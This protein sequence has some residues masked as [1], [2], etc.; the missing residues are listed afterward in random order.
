M[1]YVVEVNNL[2]R[3]FKEKVALDEVTIQLIPGKV[4][5]LLGENGA[6]KSTLIKHIIGALQPQ[7]GSVEVFGMT[8][9][10]NPVEVL[11]QIG[12]LSEDRDLPMWM[13]ANEL[14]NYT[15]SFFDGWDR[16]YA[17]ELLEKFHLDPHI[18]VK[19]MSRGEKARIGLITALAHR[20]KL[21]VL[22]EPSSGLDVSVRYDILSEV[23]RSV[24]DSGRTILFSSHL[25]DEVE[26]VT[27]NIIMINKGKKI[28]D[29]H[30]DTIK[31]QHYRYIVKFA[32]ETEEVKS[33]LKSD[34]Q[35]IRSLQQDTEWLV[36]AHEPI[37]DRIK[38]LGGEIVETQAASLENVFMD[39]CSLENHHG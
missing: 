15:A 6:G 17:Q 10:S 16:E 37:A 31:D 25:L 24:A 4:Y 8:P 14:L 32:D 36:V 13:R 19:N 1:K 11:S 27:D 5:G 12:Y 34:P 26:R 35:L 29:G 3:R 28:I 9:A 22:D 33:F 2:T 7:S 20:P 18:K 38:E 21:L 30:V 23:V 39:Y